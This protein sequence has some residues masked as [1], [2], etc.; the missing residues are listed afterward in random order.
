MIASDVSGRIVG[1]G[2]VGYLA[3]GAT[4]MAMAFVGR[5]DM[6]TGAGGAASRL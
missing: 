4:L 3:I 1:Y 5:I 2:T 6:H